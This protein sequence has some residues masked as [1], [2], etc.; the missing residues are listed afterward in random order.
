MKH[1]PSLFLYSMHVSPAQLTELA[2]L[3]G[4]PADQIHVAIIE[5]AADVEEGAENWLPSFRS[6]LLK[7]GFAIDI[8]D[9]KKI[10]GKSLYQQLALKDILWIG[11]GNTWYLRW[12]L[13]ISGAETIIKELVKAGKV[14]AGWSA[15]AMVAGPGLKH[16]HVMEPSNPAPEYITEGLHLT[17]TL[18]VPH[19]DNPDFCES[20]ALTCKLLEQNAIPYAALRDD[21]VWIADGSGYKII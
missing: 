5:N 13:R 21:Q 17:R 16:I 9:L 1:K 14:Y 11:G 19:L 10:Q 12:L 20:A 18:I 4:K 15:G 6:P 7:A 8:I 3:T 2:K